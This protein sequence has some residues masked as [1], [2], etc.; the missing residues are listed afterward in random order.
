MAVLRVRD[1]DGNI[2]EIIAIKG[3][4]GEQGPQGIQGEQGIQGNK[5]EQGPQGVQGVQGIQGVQGENGKPFT[6]AKT[7]ASIDEM[8]DDFGNPNIET[9]SF[10]CIVSSVNTEDNA[11]LYCKG[12]IEYIFIVDMSGMTGMQGEQG[13][14]GVQGIQGEAGYTPQRGTDYFTEA[15]KAELVNDVLAALPTW[16]GGSF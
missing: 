5:G 4:K 2:T 6:I 16:T 1:Q 3:D 7:Y 10:V 12:E 15:D 11:K 13:V 14:Q 8:N 9:G